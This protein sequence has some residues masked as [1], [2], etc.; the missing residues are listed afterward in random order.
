MKIAI[1]SKSS[2]AGGG[3]SRVAEDQAGWL[4]DAGHDVTHFCGYLSQTP[5]PYQQLLFP[6]TLSSRILRRID[7]GVRS[8]GI[9]DGIGMNL[10]G[11]LRDRFRGFDL[12]HF[13]DH[14]QTVSMTTISAI[15]REMPVA[16]TAHDCLHFTGGCLYP[17]GCER[18][19]AA[20]GECPQSRSIGRHDFTGYNLRRNRRAAA[21]G[22]V[23]W[24]YPSRWLE[25][26]SRKSIRH[27]GSVQTIPYGFD[28]APYGY[29]S[30]PIARQRLALPIDR[31]IVCVSAH[32]LGDRR[33]GV[34]HAL[35]AVASVRDLEP[36][37]ILVGNPAGGV[38]EKLKDVPFLFSGYVESRER[39]G[40][41]YASANAFLF[42]PLEDNLPISIQESMAAGTAVVGFA[43]GGVPEMVTDGET[44]WL[45]PTG[46][47]PSLNAALRSA[48]T[49]T[50]LEAR[51]R[52]AKER[53]LRDFD[54]K[55]CL[56][57]LTIAY[58]DA[59]ARHQR[60]T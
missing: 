1:V 12:V 59:V 7:R 20:C 26:T 52:M 36:L 44:A 14:Y 57:R 2:A 50:E 34:A 18:F 48:L 47:Q 35:D 49:S 15:S 51:G 31:R 16:F 54:V 24:I 11:V 6:R 43:T 13:H 58:S 27:G 38:A 23:T 4:L 22:D 32:Y 25:A 5:K 33:K 41:L 28:S 9:C 39:L 19:K 56:E 40:L 30:R 60:K 37:V 8:R 42:C 10:G 29:V 3:A 46:D 53:L 45:V 17:M 21:D 55:T